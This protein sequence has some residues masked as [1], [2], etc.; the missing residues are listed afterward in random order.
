MSLTKLKKIHIVIIGVFLILASG[1]AIFWFLIKP[2]QAE[3]EAAQARID[4]ASVLGNAASEAQAKRD[5]EKAKLDA[6]LAQQT[7]DAEM[8]R[9][10]PN[11]SFARR[12][13]GMLQLWQEQIYT[14]GPLIEK[15]AQDK[16]VRVTPLKITL[17][18]PPSNPNS[19]VFDKDVLVFNLGTVTVNG[20]FP[21][22]MNNIRKWN[23]CERLVMVTEP[24]LTGVSPDLQSTY[25]L[26]CFIFPV[27][28][29]GEKIPIAGEASVAGD[30]FTGG[31]TPPM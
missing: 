9:R 17:P 26:T 7:L 23:N 16:N 25:N 11:L 5:L 10:M 29:G 27:D 22:L 3:L 8:Q 19:D 13:I 2:K 12:D 31:F 4:A 14:L 24:K 21:N 30:Q 20:D 15:F 1:F 28:K 6:R 18:P